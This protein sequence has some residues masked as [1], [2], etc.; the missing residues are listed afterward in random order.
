MRNGVLIVGGGYAGVTAALRMARKL[1]GTV[2][3]TLVSAD[4]HFVERVRLHEAITSDRSISHPLAEMLAVNGVTFVHG[5]VASIA[6]GAQTATLESGQ[7]LSYERLV[8]AAG[9]RIDTSRIVG[10]EHAHALDPWVTSKL[11]AELQSLA[12]RNGSVVVVGGGLTG[13]EAAAE[14]AEV[15]PKLSVTL[16][17]GRQVGERL[18]EAAYQY[19]RGTL[20]RLGVQVRENER[21][22]AVH[23]TS[24]ETSGDAIASDLTLVAMGFRTSSVGRDAGLMVNEV[25]KVLVDPMLRAIGEP[26]IYVAG[27]MAKWNEPIGSPIPEGCKTAMPMAAHVADNVV[28]SLTGGTETPFDWRDSVL[29]ISLGRRA[30]VIQPMNVDGTPKSWALTGRAAAMVKEFICKGTVWSMRIERSGFPYMWPTTGRSRALAAA[31]G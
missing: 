17:T 2:P 10:A 18:S 5:R 13:V 30:G 4:D 19:L 25:D 7:N 29:C 11:R 1:R 24:V 21:V 15:H 9:T 12:I 31:K 6:P 20:V 14:I 16:V 28:A 26:H 23:P 27:D 8:L 22:A 3:I